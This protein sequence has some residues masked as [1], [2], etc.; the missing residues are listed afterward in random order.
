LLL[1]GVDSQGEA[2]KENPKRK[3]ERHV[4]SGRV[5]AISKTRGTGH[6]VCLLSD[7]D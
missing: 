4:S 5:S 6:A 2:E 1:T 7:T 3:E